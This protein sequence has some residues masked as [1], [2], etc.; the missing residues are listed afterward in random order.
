MPLLSPRLAG[1]A[2][3]QAAADNNPPLGLGSKGEA[4]VILQEVLIEFGA[5]MPRSTAQGTQD[6]DGIY[7]A[8]TAGA[9]RDFQ[10]RHGLIRDGIA[11]R[12]T[13]TTMDAQLLRPKPPD[14]LGIGTFGMRTARHT[15]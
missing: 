9:V 14:F 5:N 11:G 3:L 15:T 12:Q 2:R 4:V 10:T 7:G 1:H 8:E 13:L 6:P